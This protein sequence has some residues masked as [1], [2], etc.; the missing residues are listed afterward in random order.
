M[1]VVELIRLLGLG[2]LALWALTFV[3]MLAGHIWMRQR[4]TYKEPEKANY[5]LIRL[6]SMGGALAGAYVILA[7]IPFIG[8]SSTLW[9]V[10]LALGIGLLTLSVGLYVAE[11]E[12]EKKSDSGRK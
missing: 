11:G 1:A 7:E 2:L 6:L 8:S 5:E 3:F 9:P 12:L 4:G 10:L